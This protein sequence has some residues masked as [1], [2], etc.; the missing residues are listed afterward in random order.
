MNRFLGVMRATLATALIVCGLLSGSVAMAQPAAVNQAVALGASVVPLNGPWKFHTGDD[1]RW[2][3][4][5][6]D[7]SGWESVDLTPAP[8]AHDGDVGLLGYVPGWLARGHPN[9][10]GYAWYRI[11]ISVTAPAEYQLA[12]T[13][14]LLV[15]DA[16]QVFLDGRLLGASSPL[17]GPKPAVYSVQPSLFPLPPLHT[18]EGGSALLAF[19]VWMGEDTMR[20]LD[21]TGGIHIAPAI[22]ELAGAEAQHR[23]QWW[24]FFTGYVADALEPLLLVAVAAVSLVVFAFERTNRAYLWLSAALVG[25]GLLRLHQVLFFWTH[26]ENSDTV[27]LLR[28]VMLA[29]LVLA[30]W[31]MTWREWFDVRRPPWIPR[32]AAALAAILA[33]SQAAGPS[34]SIAQTGA[35]CVFLALIVYI[36]YAGIRRMGRRAWPL[37][38]AVLIGLVAQFANEWNALHVPGIWFPFGVGVSR[39]QF[40]LA[41]L[42]VVLTALLFGRLLSIARA[43]R[44]D[45]LASRTSR[46]TSA[47]T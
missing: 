43:Y 22:G 7:D 13:G 31:V 16:Y 38:P 4:P 37:L 21:D 41:G 26:W 27:E 44:I 46:S 47:R 6:F 24:D 14:P 5:S 1:P 17:S 33:A 39:T 32:A 40:A 45:D 35:R 15:D 25:N 29:P 34:M 2:A 20:S 3:D 28:N 23:L 36:T 11:R 12:L 42:I 30:A 10:W 19:R 8:G 18:R 9:Y